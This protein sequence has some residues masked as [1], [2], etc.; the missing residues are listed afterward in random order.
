MKKTIL[1]L[2]CVLLVG[3]LMAQV[4]RVIS[5]V[6]KDAQGV[7][8]PGATVLVKGTQNGVATDIE[9]Y[10]QLIVKLGDVVMIQ[11]IGLTT[12]EVV[13]TSNNSRLVYLK[14]ASGQVK[15][16]DYSKIFNPGNKTDN[17]IK[18]TQNK[19][20][21]GV[22]TDEAPSYKSKR[23]PVSKI[24]KIKF[25]APSSLYPHGHFVLKSIPKPRVRYDNEW[26]FNW[27]HTSALN[28][29]NRLPDIQSTY[30]QGRPISGVA[31]WQGP[32]T[33]EVLSWG[34][35][36]SSLNYD[37]TRPY[38]F[39]QNGRLVSNGTGASAQ[40]YN[41][42]KFF[43][44]GF[45]I[46]NVLEASKKLGYWKSIYLQIKDQRNWQPL[47]RATS[48]NNAARLRF[49][50]HKFR[51]N[52]QY[53]N[54]SA[55]L[56]NRGANW[57]NIVGS[58]LS[59]PPSFD[60]SNGLKRR[61]ALKSPTTYT[62]N[63][64]SPRT[65]A[66]GLLDNPF[67]LVNRLPDNERQGRLAGNLS[68][69]KMNYLYDE[70]NARL[71]LHLNVN[72]DVSSSRYLLGLPAQAAGANQ[73]RM[74]QRH[75][76]KRWLDLNLNSV[77]TPR[78]W[79]QALKLEVQQH[80]IFERQAVS[81]R[82]AFGFDNEN[83][84]NID[85]ANQVSSQNLDNFRRIYQVKPLIGLGHNFGDFYLE[86]DLANQFYFSST[87]PTDQRTFYL[88][89]FRTELRIN[90]LFDSQWN[91]TFDAFYNKTLRETP[92]VYNQWHYNATNTALADFQQYFERNELGNTRDVSPEIATLW[93][94]GG[95]LD[96]RGY[97]RTAIHL[98]WIYHDQ[99]TVNHLLPQLTQT[100][101]A[102][103]AN[104]GEIRNRG[105][106]L[107]FNTEVDYGSHIH[108][109]FFIN[110]LRY[111]PVVTQLYNNA[112]NVPLA[113]Y[114]EIG[115]HLVAG[116]PYGVIYGNR[117][118]RVNEQ[119]L[120]GN[121]GFPVKD[122]NL[123]V[124]GNPNPEWILQWGSEI[125]IGRW[126]L[127]W[128]LS[129]RHGG[130]RWNGTQAMLDYLGV[131]QQTAD[132]RNTK[133]FVYAGVNAAGAPNQ[134]AVDFANPANGLTRNRW[135]RYGVGGV[136]ED[137]IQDASSLRFEEIRLS[138]RGNT[139][140]GISGSKLIASVFV[141]NLLLTAPYQGLDPNTAFLSEL[142]RLGL[143]LF[144]APAMTSW[145]IKFNIFY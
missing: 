16:Y 67:G 37:N 28:R 89:E 23:V 143:N 40:A 97:R 77:L 139:F 19:P 63:D 70:I 7:P 27:Q 59:T 43:R 34:P 41:P 66:P 144:N 122:A 126:Q 130:Q 14:D 94:F 117:Y 116:Q 50:Y 8:V 31:Q 106:E 10:Y 48:R 9:G 99:I 145:G 44:N 47:S 112:V 33:G 133:D 124:L 137:Y 64:G 68:Y 121:D 52:L 49:L 46:D 138:Y 118:A 101:Q 65:P 61:D 91:I 72:F 20:G 102:T 39:D 120:I 78:F 123:G 38:D 74:T 105:L 108:W 32:E 15:Y 75:H 51:L 103:W 76:K 107:F 88:P 36:L 113:G 109:N 54:Q 134:V 21:V 29:I 13:I 4:Q 136:A 84:G 58:V 119:V 24:H 56:P 62:L 141:K 142:N 17:K 114:Q 18:P 11:A 85:L 125:R 81:R 60:Q 57:Q 115:T 87:L 140:F 80:L 22:L 73:G 55:Q 135:V 96:Y 93:K 26:R 104:V 82:N 100:G 69:Q 111:R 3:N 98:G 83:F 30:A 95:T 12:R 5:G 127:N 110:W 45:T 92:L 1:T 79:R 90:H 132:L 42:L 53:Y 71:D 2:I 35:A 128:T 6:I 131:S 129:Y 86:L 25:R